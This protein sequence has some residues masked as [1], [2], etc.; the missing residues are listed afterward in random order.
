MDSI[1]FSIFY[2]YTETGGIFTDYAGFL[3][4]YARALEHFSHEINFSKQIQLMLYL[5]KI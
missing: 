4:S 2:K 1:T 5:S 3:H